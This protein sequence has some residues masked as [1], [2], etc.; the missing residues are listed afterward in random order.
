[1]TIAEVPIEGPPAVLHNPMQDW[2]IDRRNR[3]GL[4]RLKQLAER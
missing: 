2:L 1:M 4:R 3:E